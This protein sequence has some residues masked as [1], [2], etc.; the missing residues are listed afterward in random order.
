MWAGARP[1][2]DDEQKAA[3]IG[4]AAFSVMRVITHPDA[5]RPG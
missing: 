3:G 4:P 1:T 5:S 2:A